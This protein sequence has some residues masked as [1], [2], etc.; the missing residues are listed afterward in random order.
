LGISLPPPAGTV[1][2]LFRLSGCFPGIMGQDVFRKVNAM[3]VDT[4]FQTG[5]P[6]RSFEF[7]PPKDDEGFQRL[8]KTIDRL[9]PLQPS[10]VSVTYG[11][12]GSTRRKTVE[13]AG[14]I[15]NE[16]GLRVM[17]HLTCVKHTQE[18]TAEIADELYASGIRNILAL[19]GDPPKSE[20]IFTPMEGGFQNSTE[21]V[22]FLRAR[23]A[24]VCIGVAGY[25]EGHP[26]C[27]NRT[28]DLEHLKQKIEAGGNVIITQ[29]FFDNE[30]FYRWR[31][32]A[33]TMGIVAPIIAGIM[34]IENVGQIKRFVQMCGAKIP[35]PL[36]VKLEEVEEDPDAVY[37]V[38]LEHA[39]QQCQELL[40]QGAVEGVHFYT[41]N[42]SRATVDI[43]RT[44]N[45]K[46]AA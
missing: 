32:Q 40:A 39:T 33:R 34:P 45:A 2:H 26:Q 24:D 31:D 36:L 21:L 46:F 3:R 18:E 42:K 6:T 8:Y 7:F 19:R 17:A 15:Q 43:C 16:I 22:G 25:P 14:R 11:A 41:L 30:D 44:L 23:Y 9:K 35:Q 38:G 13:L 37:Q 4:L 10:Y 27:L 1:G 5:L 12:G 20:G 29:L 28:R